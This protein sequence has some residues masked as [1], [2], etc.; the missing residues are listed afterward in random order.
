MSGV[1]WRF[2]LAKEFT[3]FRYTAQTREPVER[4]GLTRGLA[5]PCH[6]PE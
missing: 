2:V 6:E 4:T 3:E 5:P 1:I